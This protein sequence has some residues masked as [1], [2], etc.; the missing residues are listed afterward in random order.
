MIFSFLH[1]LFRDIEIW[2]IGD[3]TNANYNGM[4][5]ENSDQN[6]EYHYGELIRIDADQC[7]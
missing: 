4:I 3:L 7:G 2:D 6:G 5:T 1:G